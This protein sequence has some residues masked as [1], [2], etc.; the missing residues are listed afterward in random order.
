MTLPNAYRPKNYRVTVKTFPPDECP[1]KDIGVFNIVSTCELF[2][3][4]DAVELMKERRPG[5]HLW[6]AAAQFMGY[7]DD[8][9][10]RAKE[11]RINAMI[12]RLSCD[13]A[14]NE[15]EARLNPGLR[16]GPRDDI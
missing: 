15:L 11:R 3:R 4:A 1:E 9:K 5:A 12:G 8:E 13:H 16:W 7:A 10:E 2:A 14:R 6:V